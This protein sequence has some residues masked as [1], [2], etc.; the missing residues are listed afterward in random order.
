MAYVIL[1]SQVKKQKEKEKFKNGK[2]ND[3]SRI[4]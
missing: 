2:S 1:V 4:N 3:D